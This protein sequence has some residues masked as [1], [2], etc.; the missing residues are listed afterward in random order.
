MR[1]LDFPPLQISSSAKLTRGGRGRA[2][3]Q[4]NKYLFILLRCSNRIHLLPASVLFKFTVKYSQLCVTIF[5][6]P[7][8]CEQFFV[9][10]DTEN[11][12]RRKRIIWV[13]SCVQKEWKAELASC[14]EVKRARLEMEYHKKKVIRPVFSSLGYLQYLPVL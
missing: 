3:I 12:T 4:G 6:I 5:Y 2:Q 13:I 8:A 10:N 11:L 14:P 7:Y 9:S 1:E